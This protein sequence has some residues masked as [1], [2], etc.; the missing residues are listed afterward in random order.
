[1]KNEMNLFTK[2]EFSNLYRMLDEDKG[3]MKAL[4]EMQAGHGITE[5]KA[6]ENADQLIRLVVQ[7]EN[8]SILLSED[9]RKA[10]NEV[11]AFLGGLDQEAHM[12]QLHRLSF[13]L[14]L[15]Q[16]PQL[17][18]K[19]KEG[20]SVA[21]LFKAHCS[22]I[23][24]GEAVTQEQLEEDI[25]A[26]MGSNHV[27][28]HA[29]RAIAK[30]IAEGQSLLTTGA[31]LGEDGMRFKCLVAMDL[32]LR[33]DKKMTMEEAMLSACH[34]VEIQAVADAVACGQIAEKQAKEL[35]DVIFG[36]T[37]ISWFVLALAMPHLGLAAAATAQLVSL[38][39]LL[40]GVS[41]MGSM[42]TEPVAELVGRIAAKRCYARHIQESKAAQAL[43]AMADRAEGQK[44]TAASE[45]PA[46]AEKA[47]VQETV[48][49]PAF[50]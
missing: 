42:I 31:A 29:M 35:L 50:S 2:D 45:K 22:S 13:G 49:M 30:S 20:Q 17:Q 24:E 16:D 26:R 46:V 8:L 4:V 36:V 21:D 37:A 3:L 44:A 12:M 39:E 27:S 32:Y 34:N 5:R 15:Y 14:K 19:L 18:E 47:A 43:E 10:L 9:S 7:R 41:F 33:S 40:L 1:M 28:A 11:F 38:K 23:S 25:R 48:Q 6:Y